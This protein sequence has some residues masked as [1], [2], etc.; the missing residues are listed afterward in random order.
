MSTWVMTCLIL[1][2]S[3]REPSV[4]MKWWE[5]R[6]VL[7]VSLH[8]SVMIKQMLL[9]LW[10]VHERCLLCFSYLLSYIL[11][12]QWILMFNNEVSI[13]ADNPF[14]PTFQTSEGSKRLV[15]DRLSTLISRAQHSHLPAVQTFCLWG[16]V[17][18][19]NVAY[20]KGERSWNGLLYPVKELVDLLMNS[21]KWKRGWFSFILN[22]I[23]VIKEWNN[24]KSNHWMWKTVGPLS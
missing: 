9:F 14:G 12:Q 6:L 10:A 7:S 22:I 17:N 3:W 11:L 19:K 15:S 13:C 23:I 5:L 16:P 1:A 21:Y 24:I 18:Q 20:I 8:L 4:E 2:W